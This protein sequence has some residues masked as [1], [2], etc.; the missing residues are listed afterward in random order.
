ML[1]IKDVAKTAGVSISTVS[2]V[3]NGKKNVGRATRERVLN[4]C[5]E[6][7]YCPNFAGKNLKSK[8]NKTILFNFSDFD[9]DYFWKVIKGVSDYVNDK[10]YDLMI[11]SEKS[12]EK[13][14]QN[15][16]TSGCIIMDAAM[17]NDV[18]KRVCNEQYPIIVLDRILDHP[19]IKCVVVNS[20]DPMCTLIQE[21]INKGYRKFAFVGGLEYTEDTRERYLAFTDT[22]EKNGILFQDKNF[23]AGD[24]REKS[25]A[26]AAKIILLSGDMPEALICANDDMAIGAMKV[27]MENGVQIPE[28]IAV[29][30]F[31]NTR[32][33]E[34]LNLT[35]F[36]VPD[37][38][39]G[40]LAAQYLIDSMQG[41]GNG[42]PFRILGKVKWRNSVAGKK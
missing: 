3:L 14:M 34:V 17:K 15:N 12:C 33:S 11:C 24:Y 37:Y 22:L 40:Y 4:L 18:I 21:M 30:G 38:E 29:T 32:L 36:D 41:R 39:R 1:G 6:M 31:D 7:G 5:Q 23:F 42:E 2:N 20:Y 13:F 28:D 16:M 19:F 8:D 35:T 10:E 9:R 25:G 26:T 27:F